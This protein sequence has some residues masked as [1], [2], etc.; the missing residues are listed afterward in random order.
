[1]DERETLR[2]DISAARQKFGGY[3]EF[4]DTG[5]AFDFLTDYLIN[6]G[7]TKK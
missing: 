3:C 5:E 1:M 4:W 2:E 6:A 7:W